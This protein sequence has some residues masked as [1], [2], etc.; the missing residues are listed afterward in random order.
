M[1]VTTVLWKDT[2]NVRLASTYVGIKSFL[3]LN[4]SS[5]P[6][7]VPRYNR[8]QKEYIQVDCLQIIREYNAHMGS[9]DLMDS[10]MGRN[11]LRIKTIDMATRIFDHLLDMAIT[12][13]FV[14]YRRLNAERNRYSLDDDDEK[15]KDM[16][17]YQFRLTIAKVLCASV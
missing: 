12:N 2:K 4:P 7:K 8:K 14:L 15:Q 5:Q 11:E 16:S 17:M 6:A 1:D 10:Y 9:V 13:A 3:T